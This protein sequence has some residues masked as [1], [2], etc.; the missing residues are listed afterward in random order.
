MIKKKLNLVF[1]AMFIFSIVFSQQNVGFRQGSIN[2][3]IVNADG[4]VT[5]RLLAPLAQKVSVR[6]DWEMNG[7][8]GQMKIDTSG[9]WTYTTPT[10]PSDFYMYSF[11]VDSIRM[12]DPVNAFSTRDVGNLFSVFIVNQGNGDNYSVNDVPHGNITRTW[13]PSVQYKTDRR[14]TIYTPPAYE[15][16]KNKY[17]VL[18]LLHGSG[19]D[20][21]AWI[22]IGRLWTIMDNL[23][24]QGKIVPMI[25]VMPNGN[26]AK[27]AAPGETK[28]NFSYK[29]GM[30]N[31]LGNS[32]AGSYELSFDEIVNFTDSRYR[33]KA[34][35]SQRALAGLSMG[36][37]HSIFISAD[38]PNM[39]NYIGLFSASTPSRRTDTT[40]KA[41]SNIDVKL[42]AQKNNGLALYWIG[43]GKAD[44][45]YASVTDFRKKLDN[46]QFPYTYV[47]SERGHIWSNWRNYLLQFAPLLFK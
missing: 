40:N 47:E 41:Y 46:L 8:V 4:T 6:G 34:A 14:V 27:Q 5:F 32:V 18:Y 43:I 30:S 17:P 15:T 20:E 29:P 35:K 28:E 44:F 19:G 1:L 23:I 13:Y 25:V 3:P 21:E 42:T 33:T 12:L 45:L 7:G 39:F 11:M 9:T 37:G 10:L 22:S 2:S 31:T 24:A 26:A 16:N 36:G 38:H